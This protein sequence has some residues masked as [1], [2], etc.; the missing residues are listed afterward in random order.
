MPRLDRKH[1]TEHR[2]EDMFDLVADIEQY[3]KFVPMCRSL[4]VRSRKERGNKKLAIAD[5]TMAHSFLS[6]TFTCQVLADRAALEINVKYIDGPFSNLDNQ[7]SFKPL[8]EN[9]CEIHFVVDYELKS[10]ML[11]MAAGAVFERAFNKFVS[12]FEARADAVYQ[13]NTPDEPG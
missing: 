3:P 11:A 12:A 2:A 5:M 4:S 6:E 10:R 9:Q 1:L 8:G 13:K 7:W